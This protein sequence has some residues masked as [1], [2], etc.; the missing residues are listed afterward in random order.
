[1]A[2]VYP[3]ETT[4]AILSGLDLIY[5]LDNFEFSGLKLGEATKLRQAHE[6]RCRRARQAVTD[7]GFRFFVQH[8]RGMAL[9]TAFMDTAQVACRLEAIQA[10]EALHRDAPRGAFEPLGAMLQI[11]EAL[12]RLKHT[13]P[14]IAAVHLR[15]EVF[16]VMEA[17]VAH[18]KFEA[19]D[20]QRLAA[21]LRGQLDRWPPDKDAWIGDRA[22]GMHTY[23]LIR[24]GYLLSILSI[25]EIRQ[26]R[27]EVGIEKL[28][29]LIAQNVDYDEYFFLRTM[30]RAI[31]ACEKPFAER[32]TLFRSMATEMEQ[33]RATPSYPVLADQLLLPNMESGHR[34]QALDRARCEAWWIALALSV[35]EPVDDHLVNPLT[36]LPYII[37]RLPTR[38]VVDG[39]DPDQNER[40]V[41]IPV[42]VPG[43]KTAVAN[44]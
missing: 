34:L 44:G 30:R 40:P 24:D 37:E 14:R 31:E 2:H 3:P 12:G 23:E 4:A 18:D 41:R 15:G 9:D 22:Q 36:G 20:R 19:S 32:K 42:R 38:V 7:P 33:M 43:E 25:E 28:G 1:L 8:R 26:Y 16:H 5:P 6:D 35:N 21:M 11:T 29:Q 27:N 10:A 17:M 13:V 39:I